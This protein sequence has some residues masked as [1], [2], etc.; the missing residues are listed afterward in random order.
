MADAGLGIGALLQSFSQAFQIGDESQRKREQ[1][2]M[3]KKLLDSQIKTH[4]LQQ[5]MVEQQIKEHLTKQ[6][7]L[8]ALAKT[9]ETGQPG[10]PGQGGPDINFEQQGDQSVVPED[11]ASRR[12][13][14]GAGTPAKPGIPPSP[15][16]AALVRSGHPELI[17][18]DQTITHAPAGSMVFKGGQQ[19][20]QV[21]FTQA[22]ITPY[23]QGRLDV[24]N[25]KL[26]ATQD[27]PERPITLAPGGIAVDPKT[28]QPI[29]SNPNKPGQ[30]DV[31]PAVN[32]KS[33]KDQLESMAK[34]FKRNQ[35]NAIKP[36]LESKANA[37]GYTIVGVRPGALYGF[38]IDIAPIT[39]DTRGK[40]QQN[41]MGGDSKE[42]RL[43]RLFPGS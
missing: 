3:Q 5:R 29:A 6:G 35:I 27:R 43:N 19:L 42:E 24:E 4:D 25:K 13:I 34:D 12:V 41:L 22:P 33:A 10:Q 36:Q 17:T 2:E 18:K 37:L 8:E 31:G 20:G 9:L 15:M 1:M 26:Q 23:Q 32:F 14:I 7:G 30:A 16:N 38:N 39:K 28:G 11:T 21:P 40:A